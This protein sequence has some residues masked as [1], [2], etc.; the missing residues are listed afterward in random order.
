M[1]NRKQDRWFQDI[2]ARQRNVVFP[3]TVQNEARFWRN[4]KETPWTTSTKIG[5]AIL[6][7]FVGG[8]IVAILVATLQQGIWTAL[9]LAAGM[10]LI[11][12]PIFALIAWATRRS[13]RN[14]HNA[15]RGQSR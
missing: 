7:F 4:L 10:L 2:E 6:A 1:A 13:L 3:D 9:A 11:F 14:I 15:R 12:G 8:G 5:V